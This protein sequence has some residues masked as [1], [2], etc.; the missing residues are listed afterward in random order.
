MEC[1]IAVLFFKKILIATQEGENCV[2][3]SFRKIPEVTKQIHLFPG[4]N[5]K[6]C[7][8]QGK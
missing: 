3:E 6:T 1:H 7:N 4:Y 2:V 8:K 5:F